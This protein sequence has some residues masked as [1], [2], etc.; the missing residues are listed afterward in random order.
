MK[1]Q[2]LA[3][4]ASEDQVK[5]FN[6]DPRI[7]HVVHATPGRLYTVLALTAYGVPSPVRSGVYLDLVDDY[8]RWS[9][10]PMFLFELV[11]NRPS[12]YWVAKKFPDSTLALWPESFYRECYHDRLTDGEPEYVDDFQRVRTLLES[13]F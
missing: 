10:N 8:G 1:V 9:E 4:R 6:L 5:Q 3:R 13:E 11:D 7:G 12:K 2:C